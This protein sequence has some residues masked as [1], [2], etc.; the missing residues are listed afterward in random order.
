M[1]ES[2]QVRRA[3][4]REAAKTAIE[5]R[6]SQ[7][8]THARSAHD[9]WTMFY[10]EVLVPHGLTFDDPDTSPGVEWFRRAF[11]AGVSSMYELMMRVSPDDVSEDRGV[12]MLNRLY[13]ELQT[14]AKGLK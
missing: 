4:E 7:R 5:Q 8:V 9:M 1:T 3:R 14:F 13:E 12:E 11:Y 6:V 2:R 10:Q